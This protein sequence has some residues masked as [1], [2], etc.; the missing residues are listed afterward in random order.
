MKFIFACADVCARVC[1]N[2]SAST[3]KAFE[4]STMS[5]VEYGVFPSRL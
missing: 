2:T 4:K 5:P 1:L 3:M